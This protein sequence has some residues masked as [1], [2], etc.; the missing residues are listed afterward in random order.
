MLQLQ[1]KA[2]R[3]FAFNFGLPRDSVAV[4]CHQ[5]GPHCIHQCHIVCS[6]GALTT[7]MAMPL[8]ATGLHEGKSLLQHPVEH[9]AIEETQLL[10]VSW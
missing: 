10:R 8:L 4:G 3:Y 7:V 5:L 1:H 6:R 9:P 2:G